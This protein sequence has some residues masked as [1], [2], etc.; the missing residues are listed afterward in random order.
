MKELLLKLKQLRERVLGGEEKIN[1]SLN[2]MGNMV[3]HP[4]LRR[5][6]HF[7]RDGS[8]QTVHPKKT[9]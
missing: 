6:I 2:S 9:H 1:D 8:V 7:N 5:M 4:R 3:W